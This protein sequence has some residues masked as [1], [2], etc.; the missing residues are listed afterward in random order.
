MTDDKLNEGDKALLRAAATGEG[1]VELTPERLER[2]RAALDERAREAAE[3]FPKLVAACP[4]KMRLA[5]TAQVFE[6]LVAHATEGGTFRY[7]I[8][9]R[10]GFD[11]DAYT[12]LYLAGG[13]TISNEFDLGRDEPGAQE[14]P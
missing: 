12:P 6:A 5:V 9:D 13:M 2:M 10:L 7:L 3:D 8:Y 1:L 4:Y 11:V 14:T